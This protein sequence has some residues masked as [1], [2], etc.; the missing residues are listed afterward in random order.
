MEGS[1]P[2]AD[3]LIRYEDNS[4]YRFRSGAGASHWRELVP[5]V[6]VSRGSAPAATLPAAQR[7]TSMP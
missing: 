4:F 7:P 5:T 6:A 1:P 3:K 2:P